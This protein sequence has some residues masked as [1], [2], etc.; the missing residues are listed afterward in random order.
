MIPNIDT[1]YTKWFLFGVAMGALL[2]DLL[3]AERAAQRGIHKLRLAK[4]LQSLVEAFEKGHEKLHCILLL[5]KIHRL[6]LQP[7]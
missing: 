2:A 3:V 6:S 4:R 7:I 5:A 1:K